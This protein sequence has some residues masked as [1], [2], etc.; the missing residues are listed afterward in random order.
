MDFHMSAEGARLAKRLAAH[1]AN[2]WL[3]SRVCP[4]MGLQRAAVSEILSAVLAH[5][6]I[7]P[8]VY[9]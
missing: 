9:L 1:T 6:Q 5:V 3:L 7:L 8:A 4:R 2:E